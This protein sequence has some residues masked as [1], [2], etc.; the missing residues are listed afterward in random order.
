[1]NLVTEAV[2]QI[3]GDSPNQVPNARLSMMTGG[4]SVQMASSALFGSEQTL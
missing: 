2:R 3:R 1:M 4:P